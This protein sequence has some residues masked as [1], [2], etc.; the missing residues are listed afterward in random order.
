MDTAQES[1][2]PSG[3]RARLRKLGAGDMELLR[4][5][6]LC[7]AV[8]GV[9]LL[10]RFTG[11]YELIDEWQ[12]RILA[13]HPFYISALDVQIS[14]LSP[15]ATFAVCVGLTFY[16][17]GVLLRCRSYARRSHICLLAAVALAMP[18]LLC[19]LWHGVL[20]VGQPLLCV[21]LIWL[22]LVP[23]SF[24]KKTFL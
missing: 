23:C 7:I 17:G 4:W 14:L 16:L 9:V 1:T 5:V 24:L 11:L 22:I 10:L 2:P 15:V 13:G 3:W 21:V 8:P 6:S 19:V 18:G 20:Y 12:L